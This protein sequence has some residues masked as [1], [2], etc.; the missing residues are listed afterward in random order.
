[1]HTSVFSRFLVGAMIVSST[2]PALADPITLDQA[3]QRAAKRPLV[4]MAGAS[5]DAARSEAR[6]A[7]RAIYNP[8]LGVAAGPRLGG[9]ETL[10]D[11]QVTL[12]Q[13]FELGG[14]RSARAE[15]A[16]AKLDVT[17]ADLAAA[18]V[19]ARVETWRAF[20]LALV[21]RE[22]TAITKDAEQVALQ[23]D[24]ATRERM[25]SGFATQ[26]QVNL[27]VAEVG[28]ASHDRLDTLRRYDQALAVLATAVGAGPDERLEP[29]GGI[30][31]PADLS[32]T[33]EAL[34][35]RA[36]RSRPDLRAARSNV[37]A[38]RAEARFADA[39]AI[40][41]LTLGVSYAREQDAGL[42]SHVI[43]ASA[44]VALPLRNR[45]QGAREATR[46]RARRADLDA[47]RIATEVTREVRVALEGYT[48]AREA[49]A[50]FDRE[51]NEKL[52][53]NL[54]LARQ[55]YTS[56]KI[57]YFEFNVVRRELVASRQ[58]YLDAV[59]EVIES[60]SALLQ[61]GGEVKP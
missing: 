26:L 31:L 24:I 33:L 50:G 56:G 32:A 15:V 59:E 27:A 1:M 41:D 45:N 35:D 61:A 4:A 9:G 40:P 12:S 17:E 28:R 58:A 46:A 20:Q 53:E 6:G 44:S 14:K 57:D 10:L 30:E 3:F 39:Q 34:T 11:F 23:I 37:V 21:L 8:E 7:R 42:T 49:V 29:A 16:V 38:S 2:G 18:T 60:W 52:H 47:A 51:V 48:R 54:E 5:T 43:L 25:K 22:R 55:S 36:L 13:V 19:G